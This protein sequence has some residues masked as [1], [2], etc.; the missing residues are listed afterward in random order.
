V[1]HQVYKFVYLPTPQLPVAID[2]SI[3]KWYHMDRL[4]CLKIRHPIPET[5][6]TVSSANP[7][8][9]I[10]PSPRVRNALRL[11]VTG[12]CRTKREASIAAGLHPHYLTMLTA[13]GSGSDPAKQ[14]MEEIHTLMNDKTVD[15]SVVIQK[16][17]RVG[18]GTMAKLA[19][20]G[21]NE[22]IQLDA[23]KSLAD[24]SPETAGVQKIQVDGLSIASMD[25]QALADALVESARLREQYSHIAE[26]GLIEVDVTQ[27]APPDAVPGMPETQR[28]IGPGEGSAAEQGDTTTPESEDE[29][30]SRLRREIRVEP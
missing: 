13:P 8:Q 22:R 23:A 21:G 17:G 7:L 4:S 25:A 20:M 12:A 26:H 18:L 10:K 5:E 19:V 1:R 28:A 29:R 15:M 27:G 16:L 3:E 2:I 9:N 6:G 30:A 14:M 11:Y 24:R